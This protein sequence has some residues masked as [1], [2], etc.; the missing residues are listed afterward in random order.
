MQP[1]PVVGPVIGQQGQGGDGERGQFHRLVGGGNPGGLL[2]LGVKAGQEAAFVPCGD[3]QGCPARDE[4][5]EFLAETA[6]QRGEG[7]D[8]VGGGGTGQG[9]A[10]GRQE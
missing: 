2:E 5:Q 6:F 10:V 8:G 1:D 7:D 4:G 3:V 9:A